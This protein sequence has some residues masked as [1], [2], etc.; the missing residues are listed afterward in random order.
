MPPD[1]FE[2]W[3]AEPLEEVTFLSTDAAAAG[4][5]IHRGSGRFGRWHGAAIHPG[6]VEKYGIRT[7]LAVLVPNERLYARL[8]LLDGPG[9]TG[10]SLL[11]AEVV[12]GRIGAAFEQAGLVRELREATAVDERVRIARDLHDGVVQTL[13]ATALQLEA[14]RPLLRRDPERAFSRVADLQDTLAGQ[15]RELRAFIRALEPDAPGTPLDA[16]AGLS[17]RLGEFAARLER[18]WGVA[19]RWR[20]RPGGR[21]GG[22]AD[23]LRP[24]ADRQRGHRQRGQARGGQGRD[25]GCRARRG[26]APRHRRGRRPGLRL[27]RPPRPRSPRQ[28]EPRAEKPPLACDRAGRQPHRGVRRPGCEARDRPAQGKGGAGVTIRLVLADNHPLLLDGIV[29]LFEHEPDIEVVA[30]CDGGEAALRAVREHAPDVLLL[31]LNMP[32]VGGMEVLRRLARDGSIVRVVVLTAEVAEDELLEAIRL[33]V[34]GIVLKETA[35]ELL[36]RCVRV[37][38][39]GGQWL[40]AEQAGRALDRFLAREADRQRSVKVLTP[41]ETE[42]VRLVSEG[43]RNKEIAFRLGLTEGTVKVNLHR[44]YE[45][46]GVSTRV[47]LANYVRREGI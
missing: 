46:L 14:L 15:Q 47:E 7:A 17:E 44:I 12:A 22:G 13:A 32:P 30:R 10:D 40:D 41:R 26:G 43:L 38:H 23:R 34:R 42:L 3:V 24:A 6:L 4:A 21:A 8:F 9:L 28:E 2:R 1:R 29:R 37:V 33:G 27:H 35:P 39:G 20:L 45:K 25:A 18:E 36:V 19:V 5:V 11:V 31:D 16:Q